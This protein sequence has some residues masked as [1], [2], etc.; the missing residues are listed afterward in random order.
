MGT[1]LKTHWPAA[2]FKARA[3]QCFRLADT[4]MQGKDADE[5]RAMGKEFEAQAKL[6]EDAKNQVESSDTST[7]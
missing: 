5:I 7:G 3:E 6:A 2:W 1:E 4:M